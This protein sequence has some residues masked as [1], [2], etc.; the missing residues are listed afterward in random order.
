MSKKTFRELIEGDTPVL[1]DFY[2][3]WC[4]PCRMMAPVLE[5]LKSELGEKVSIIKINVD[6]NQ[7]IAEALQIRSI[8]TLVLFKN[9]DLKW[10]HSG[11]VPVNQLRK[12]LEPFE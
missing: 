4:A 9:G 5:E 11:L 3:D 7:G 8:P 6:H 12:V 1:I 2:A 10:R